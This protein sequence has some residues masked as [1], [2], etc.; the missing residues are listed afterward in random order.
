[1][2]KMKLETKIAKKSQLNLD[3]FT[4]DTETVDRTISNVRIELGHTR[5]PVIVPTEVKEKRKLARECNTLEL[6]RDLVHIQDEIRMI[7]NGVY[8]K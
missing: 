7:F 2:K 8:N 4:K 5:F 6:I 1:M 3:L